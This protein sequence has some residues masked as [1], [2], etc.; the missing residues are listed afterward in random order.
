MNDNLKDR[1]TGT[2]GHTDGPWS[3]WETPGALTVDGPDRVPVASINDLRTR[4][5]IGRIN[6]NLIALAPELKAEVLRQDA[7]IEE[8][9]DGKICEWLEIKQALEALEREV[10]SEMKGAK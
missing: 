7:L 5:E 1:L 10:I 8:L 9:V 4:R 6:A 2:E 3:T